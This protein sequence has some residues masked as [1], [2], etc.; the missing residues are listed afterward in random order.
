V[1]ILAISTS[2]AGFLAPLAT[3]RLDNHDA[4]EFVWMGRILSLCKS[5]RCSGRV[6]RW[7]HEDHETE[8]SGGSW[9][10]ESSM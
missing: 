5:S 10:I 4:G 7:K 6:S 9:Y 3:I 2:K 1:P 8:S